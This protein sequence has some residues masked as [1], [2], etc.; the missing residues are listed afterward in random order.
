MNIY[1]INLIKINL[2]IFKYVYKNIHFTDVCILNL[3]HASHSILNFP[4]F[5]NFNDS[6]VKIRIK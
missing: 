2:N 3:L 5:S 1:L 4:V 6:K